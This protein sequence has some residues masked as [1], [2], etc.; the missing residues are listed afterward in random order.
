MK[1]RRK[2]RKPSAAPAFAGLTLADCCEG[3]T[4][5]KCLISGKPYCAHPRK[6]GLTFSDMSNGAADAR[7]R[8][9]ERLIGGSK[10]PAG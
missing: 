1:S 7:L 10:A 6:G 3:C 5:K 2:T 9:A 8:A 4:A